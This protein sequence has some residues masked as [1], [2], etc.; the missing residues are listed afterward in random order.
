MKHIQTL[1]LPIILV[2]IAILL[3]IANTWL[4]V[5]KARLAYQVEQYKSILREKTKFITKLETE[6]DFL[7]SPSRLRGYIKEFELQ[8]AR[9]GHLL[10]IPYSQEEYKEQQAIPLE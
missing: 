4:G 3:I 5:E 6:R 9:Q 8:P 10:T 7:L 2:S 1:L